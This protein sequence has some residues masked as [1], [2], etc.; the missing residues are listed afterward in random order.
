MFVEVPHHEHGDGL[1]SARGIFT[2]ELRGAGGE[3]GVHESKVRD[4]LPDAGWLA[5]AEMR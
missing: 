1:K 5:A 4:C 2:E 3:A